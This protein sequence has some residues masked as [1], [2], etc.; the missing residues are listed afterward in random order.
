MPTRDPLAR[1][2]TRDRVVDAHRRSTIP[3]VAVASLS[4]SL[5]QFPASVLAD[6]LD[7]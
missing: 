5:R 4:R 6:G 2:N 1:A 7:V 3:P